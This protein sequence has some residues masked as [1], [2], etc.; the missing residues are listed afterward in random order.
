[1]FHIFQDR[2]PISQKKTSTVFHFPIYNA[3]HSYL[4]FEKADREELHHTPF[5]YLKETPSF[6]KNDTNYF[7]T[8][9]TEKYFKWSNNNY[10]KIRDL[11]DN[12]TTIITCKRDYDTEYLNDGKWYDFYFTTYCTMDVRPNLLY[13]NNDFTRFVY[14]LDRAGDLIMKNSPY[15]LQ[16]DRFGFI[17][18]DHNVEVFNME[19]MYDMEFPDWVFLLFDS[20]IGF[21]VR[22]SIRTEHKN[23]D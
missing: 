17:Y 18:L 16:F 10:V 11:L 6:S 7:Y 4:P 8:W 12:G 14:F 23:P 2:I 15:R 13:Y 22:K 1:L 5:N 20:L 21:C 9:N 19:E 3:K